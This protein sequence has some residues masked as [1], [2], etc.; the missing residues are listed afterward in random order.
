VSLTENLKALHLP[1]I[2]Q[3]YEEAA[4]EAERE[5]LSYERYLHEVVQRECEERR[6]N[7]A[8]RMLRQSHLPLEKSLE[9]F[10]GRRR[11]RCERSWMVVF[12]IEPKMRLC[13]EIQEA[14]RPISYRRWGKS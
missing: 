14:A 7:R 11:G 2:R 9:A 10:D 8:A 13:S 6:E 3:C 12:W 1:T 4:R 5:T